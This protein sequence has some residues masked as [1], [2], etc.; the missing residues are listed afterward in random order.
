MVGDRQLKLA[1]RGCRPDRDG[2]VW[3]AVRQGVAE[4]IGKKLT[5]A[6]SVRR[7]RTGDGEVD[8]DHP[9]R[10]AGAQFID[11]LLQIRRKLISRALVQTDAAAKPPAREIQHVVDESRHARRAALHIG[12]QQAR[13]LRRRRFLQQDDAR[14]DGGQRV[15]QVVAQ[16]RDELLPQ[17]FVGARI[18]QGCIGGGRAGLCVKLGGDERGEQFKHPH[19]VGTRSRRRFRIYGAEGA[20]KSP[21]R[22]HN[23]RRNV[24][25]QPVG[26]GRVVV[27]PI[28]T[29]GGLVESDGGAAFPDL[30]AERRLDGQFAAH[31]QA[32][33]NLIL[34]RAGE[35]A[36]RADMG[37]DG[38]SHAGR[39]QADLQ[40]GRHIGQ[41]GHGGQGVKP[42]RGKS[43]RHGLKVLGRPTLEV[44]VSVAAGGVRQGPRPVEPYRMRRDRPNS[45]SVAGRRRAG[46]GARVT[47]LSPRAAA[48]EPP[49]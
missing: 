3:I 30:M 37:D 25:F 20:E 1:V 13:P 46:N 43:E 11:Y 23:G 36:V 34:H 10:V 31:R 48:L 4:Q 38:V 44:E 8:V 6:I 29:G 39:A 15:A 35:P 24:A 16:H 5:D 19:D 41:G 14:F 22:Q 28:R 17:L 26:L 40:D 9:S 2:P 7:D 27:D 18:E 45:A 32:E 47:G 42:I 12:E 21:V 33:L 49:G